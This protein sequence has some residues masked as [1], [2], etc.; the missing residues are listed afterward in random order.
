MLVVMVVPMLVSLVELW[1]AFLV[2]PLVILVV[3][4]VVI[5]T[6]ILVG[7]TATARW[8]GVCDGRAD[9]LARQLILLSLPW[10]G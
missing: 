9:A 6:V 4:L 2:V 8:S 5:L 10:I 3:V 1:M 7:K